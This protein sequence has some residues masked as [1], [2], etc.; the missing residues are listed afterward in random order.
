[1][2]SRLSRHDA[3][4]RLRGCLENGLIDFSPHFAQALKDDGLDLGDARQVLKTGNI[5][6]EP[7]FDVRRQQW[8]YRIEGKEPDGKWL[9]MIFTFV[10]VDEAVMI[11]AY[12]KK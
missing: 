10:E 4:A 3:L 12:L 7:E 9:A 11:T 8:R 1:M 2:L 6:D 5:H